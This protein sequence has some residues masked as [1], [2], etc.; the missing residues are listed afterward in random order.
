MLSNRH[1]E[2]R[3]RQEFMLIVTIDILCLA[4][5]QTLNPAEMKSA[6]QETGF[7]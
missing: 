4:F 3:R 5:F 2:K 7:G 1:T 6:G